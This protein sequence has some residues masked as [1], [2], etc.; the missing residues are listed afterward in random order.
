MGQKQSPSTQ[1]LTPVQ[2]LPHFPQ[3]LLSLIVATQVP[4]QSVG[5]R[6][7][8]TQLPAM[9]VLPPVQAFPQLPQLLLSVV[10]SMQ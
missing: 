7:G 10:T 4:P 1:V 9:Q 2:T 3:L 5:A 6:I 8:Q